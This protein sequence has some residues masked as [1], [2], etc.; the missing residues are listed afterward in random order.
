MR[1]FVTGY[2]DMALTHGRPAEVE[3][4]Q[5]GRLFLANDNTGEI[6]W[7]APFSLER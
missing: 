4:A 3:F 7:I 5:D 6:I 1:D 2:E